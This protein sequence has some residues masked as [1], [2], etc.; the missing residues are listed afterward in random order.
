MTVSRGHARL[1]RFDDF[2]SNPGGLGAAIYAPAGLAGSC[3]LVVVLHGST[4]DAEAYDAGS[5]WSK[6][7]DEYG[8]ALLFP[9]QR[10]RNSATLGFHWFDPKHNARDVG[11]ALSIRQMI[12]RAT[13]D[14]GIDPDRVFVTG[15]SSGGA[16]ACVLLATYPEVFSGGAVIGGLAYRSA[17]SMFQ[18]L[19][20]MKGYG[21]PS[22][23]RLGAL[24]RE[25]TDHD[26][27]WPR[28]SV[29]HGD[30]DTTVDPSNAEAIVQQWQELHG[31]QGPPT[32]VEDVAG[33]ERRVWRCPAGRDVIEA[34]SIADMAHGTPIDADRTKGCGVP[35]SYMLDVGISSTRH[36]ATFWELER[37]REP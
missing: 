32:L 37:K 29:W 19:L 10:R 28:I 15:L 35:G 12:E 24:V 2:G 27:S 8:F 7:A 23:P 20:R 25:A 33:H 14:L 13:L 21:G 4:Q 22:L 34:Y 31:L 9:E 30:R 36:I 6:L 5:G 16:M 1:Q 26:A 17:N 3:P 11:E 18:A